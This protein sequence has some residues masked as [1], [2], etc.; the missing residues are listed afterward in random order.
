MSL[1]LRR[2]EKQGGGRREK[3]ARVAR[4]GGGTGAV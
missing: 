1:D 4:G 3:G 2:H